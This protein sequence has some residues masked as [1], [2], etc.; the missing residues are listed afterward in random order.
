MVSASQLGYLEDDSP[1]G[2]H[3]F[4][5][6]TTAQGIDKWHIARENYGEEPMNQK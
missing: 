3:K 1:K 6:R 5:E 4:S 2:Q